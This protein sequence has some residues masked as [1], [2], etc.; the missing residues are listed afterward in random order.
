MGRTWQQDTPS[1]YRAVRAAR[2]HARHRACAEARHTNCAK[3]RRAPPVLWV[4]ERPPRPEATKLVEALRFIRW[5]KDLGMADVPLVGGKNASPGEMYCELKPQGIRVPNGFAISAEP[6]RFYLVENDLEARVRALLCGP[7]V[8][9]L[10]Q[11]A[12]G[13]RQVR[14]AILNT[15]LPAELERQIAL[16][17]GELCREYGPECHVAVRSSATAEDLPTASFAGQ[18]ESYLNVRDV[19]RFSTPA[20]IVTPR[21][22][23]T[24]PFCIVSIAALRM[25]A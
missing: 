23:R 25:R 13:G 5:F 2:R 17:H 9:N 24:E 21:C 14:E 8:R 15:P 20:A 10:A 12:E 22:L 3:G 18:Q 6:Y 11:L 1:Q 19:P 7:D 4:A 16:G